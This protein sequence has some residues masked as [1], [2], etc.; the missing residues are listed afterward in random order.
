[1]NEKEN[2]IQEKNKREMLEDRNFTVH[3]IHITLR[4]HHSIFS[5]D[6]DH[7]VMWQS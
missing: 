5:I 6:F 1:V 4:E 3:H 7:A 2:K